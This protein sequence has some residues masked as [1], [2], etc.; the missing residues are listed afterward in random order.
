MA[1]LAQVPFPASVPLLSTPLKSIVSLHAQCFDRFSEPI[2]A[3]P[4]LGEDGSSLKEWIEGFQRF[5][6][7]GCQWVEVAVENEEQQLEYVYIPAQGGTGESGEAQKKLEKPVHPGREVIVWDELL[8]ILERAT[9]MQPLI[10]STPP[11]KPLAS[12]PFPIPRRG[13]RVY[14]L[15]ASCPSSSFPLVSFDRRNFCDRSSPSELVAPVSLFLTDLK[16]S[17]AQCN[18]DYIKVKFY[19]AFGRV[20]SDVLVKMK[21]GAALAKAGGDTVTW[22][23]FESNLLQWE[24]YSCQPDFSGAGLDTFPGVALQ[25]KRATELLQPHIFQDGLVL[26]SIRATCGQDERILRLE[27]C[28]TT[29]PPGN[30][31]QKL[32]SFLQA[33]DALTFPAPDCMVVTITWHDRTGKEN[34]TPVLIKTPQWFTKYGVGREGTEKEMKGGREDGEWLEFWLYKRAMQ[35]IRWPTCEEVMNPHLVGTSGNIDHSTPPSESNSPND[36]DNPNLTTRPTSL[37]HPYPAVPPHFTWAPKN[38]DPQIWQHARD[39]Y[40]IASCPGQQY[41]LQP[42]YHAPPGVPESS[43][44]LTNLNEWLSVVHPCVQKASAMGEDWVYVAF[45]WAESSELGMEAPRPHQEYYI[46]TRYWEERKNA[47]LPPG[48]RIRLGDFERAMRGTVPNLSGSGWPAVAPATKSNSP[49]KS[50]DPDTWARAAWITAYCPGQK[51]RLQPAY[52]PRLGRPD[53]LTAVD[54]WLSAIEACARSASTIPK[55]WIHISLS[56]T[57]IALPHE[58]YFIVTQHWVE[59]G[60]KALPPP[61]PSIGLD[62]FVTAVRDMKASGGL[63]ADVGL[64]IQPGIPPPVPLKDSIIHPEEDAPAHSVLGVPPHANWIY[65]NET[66]F[67]RSIPYHAVVTTFCGTRFYV[68]EP[69][70]PSSRWVIRNVNEWLTAVDRCVQDGSEWRRKWLEVSISWEGPINRAPEPYTK[71]TYNVVP[72]RWEGEAA[73]EKAGPTS[74]VLV[75]WI[76]WDH[77]AAALREVRWHPGPTSLPQFPA[78]VVLDPLPPV[79]GPAPAPIRPANSLAPP[80]PLFPATPKSFWGRLHA[81]LTQELLLISTPRPLDEDAREYVPLPAHP[82]VGPVTIATY[83]AD[84]WVFLAENAYPQSVYVTF[85]VVLLMFVGLVFMLSRTMRRRASRRRAMIGDTSEKTEKE[86]C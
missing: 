5:W 38:M 39:T 83:I 42:S 40:A 1:V 14:L 57:E 63:R 47:P 23:A 59:Q 82:R 33:V 20:G 45:V 85:G 79:N 7:D 26:N 36:P 10:H 28:S 55:D 44:P 69:N 72:K 22:E 75:G 46:I 49:L 17:S 68:L 78:G 13:P 9:W 48:L 64:A 65:T 74:K 27:D 60:E 30:L 77:F 21:E 67:A 32:G 53:H 50:I 56:E 41:R 35:A 3:V 8:R 70:S 29:S 6:D 11:S 16:Q 37:T 19:G 58:H 84:V 80:Y 51:Y 12:T 66:I 76:R 62:D 34:G 81:L 61:G 86:K 18:D 4:A 54:K 15:R 73:L 24:W 43:Q 2:Q 31:E 25:T 71:Q 52:I